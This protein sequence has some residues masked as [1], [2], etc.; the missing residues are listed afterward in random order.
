M[1][2]P[3]RRGMMAGVRG[4]PFT[5]GP[6]GS[7][8]EIPQ[9]VEPELTAVRRDCDL[10]GP[11]IKCGAADAPEERLLLLRRFSRWMYVTSLL[12]VLIYVLIVIVAARS[13][14]RVS[15]CR[16]C[17]NRWIAGEAAFLL[18]F[19]AAFLTLLFP[20]GYSTNGGSALFTISG[21]ILSAIACVAFTF[22][23]TRTRLTLRLDRGS[24]GGHSGG[25]SGLRRRPARA[26]LR[27]TQWASPRIAA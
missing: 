27:V 9:P 15:V 7:G 17:Q 8:E 5:T 24:R 21:A 16:R 26:G 2:R 1:S 6:R 4:S 25:G 19:L 10:R 3:M 22:F 23:A 14:H 12:I 20:I 18:S 11:C 13:E